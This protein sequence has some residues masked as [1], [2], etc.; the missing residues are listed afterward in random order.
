M[1]PHGASDWSVAKSHAVDVGLSYPIIVTATSARLAALVV[2]RKQARSRQ[3]AF[4]AWVIVK[5]LL[6]CGSTVSHCWCEAHGI[7][8]DMLIRPLWT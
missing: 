6:G 1:D 4:P 7:D 8:P 2:S 5:Q 3:T